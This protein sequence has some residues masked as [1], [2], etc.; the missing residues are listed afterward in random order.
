[1]FL[2]Y[3]IDF[4]IEKSVYA[5]VECAN[6]NLLKV[7]ISVTNTNLQIVYLKLEHPFIDFCSYICICILVIVLGF[8]VG[9]RCTINVLRVKLVP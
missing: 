7:Q 9:L 2:K 8:G 1:M 6:A 4:L 5:L 3:P